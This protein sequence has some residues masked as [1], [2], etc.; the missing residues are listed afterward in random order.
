[1]DYTV[2]SRL[3]SERGKG[4]RVFIRRIAIASAM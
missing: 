1:M 3:E 4:Q 2:N